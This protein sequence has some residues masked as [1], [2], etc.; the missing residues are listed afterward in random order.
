[1]ETTR[2]IRVNSKY[3][4]PGG[5]SSKFYYSIGGTLANRVLDLTL[6]SARIPRLFG[7]IYYPVNELTFSIG[8]RLSS[9]YVTPGQYTAIQLAAQISAMCVDLQVDCSYNVDTH[10]FIF[11]NRGA[12]TVFML[13]SSP[14]SS[15]IGLTSDISLTNKPTSLPYPP[16]LDG[17]ACVYIQSDTLSMCAHCVDTPAIG[18]YIPLIAAVDCNVPYGFTISYE[19]K[20]INSQLIS[21]RLSQSLPN[22]SYFDIQLCDQYGNLLSDLPE[23]SYVDLV[24][25]ITVDMS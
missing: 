20:D 5:T 22:L 24:F 7:N 10:R 1:M 21:Y 3:R 13:A 25:K 14:I 18:T 11:T 8:G 9:V 2:F 19:C 16:T 6:V 4:Q 23:N 12:A 15:Y 17:P